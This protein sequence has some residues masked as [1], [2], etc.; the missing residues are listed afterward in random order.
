MT[1]EQIR[2]VVV[3]TGERLDLVTADLGDPALVRDLGARFVLDRAHRSE[4]ADAVTVEG[5]GVGGPFDG[6]AVTARF[7]ADGTDIT[8]TGERGWTFVKAFPMLARGMFE[9]LSFQDPVLR[10][11]PSGNLTF[12][13]KLV[14]TTVL[15]PLDLLFAGVEHDVTGTITMIA[16]IP[17]LGFEV[18]PVPM[19]V[20]FGPAGHSLDLGLFTLDGLRYEIL[21]EPEMDP[22][23]ADL[24]VRGSVTVTGA[25]PFTAYGKR[26]DVLISARIGA[27]R[28][29]ILLL[30]DFREAGRAAFADIAAF[31][32]LPGL[33]IPGDDFQITAPV[34][35]SEVLIA[36]NPG[37]PTLIP[38]L[39]VTLETTQEWDAGVLRLQAVDVVFRVDGPLTASPQVDVMVTGLVAIGARGTLE[40]TAE[41]GD[42]VSF[43]GALREGDP[44]PTLR[45]IY[46]DFTGS[47]AAGHL[48]DLAVHKF[49]VTIDKP[50][51]GPV[52]AAGLLELTGSWAVADGVD[53]QAVLFSLN[54]DGPD[55]KFLTS[56]ELAVFAIRLG[57]MASYTTGQGWFF[58]GRSFPDQEV[59]VGE[60]VD[61]LATRFGAMPPPAPISGLV[62]HD[63][64][65][66][67]ATVDTRFTFGAGVRFPIDTTTVDLTV[68]IDTGARTYGGRIRTVLGDGTDLRFDVHFSDA[69][70]ATRYAAS[71]THGDSD[72]MPPVKSL[73]GALSPTAAGFVPDGLVVSVRDAVLA[74]TGSAYVF[75]VDLVATIDLSRLPV[76]GP[77]L[78]GDGIVGFDPLRVIAATGEVPGT[79]VTKLNALLPAEAASL[80]VQTLPS[81]FT[82]SGLLKLGPL[83]Q[84][85]TLPVTAPAAAPTPVEAKTGDNVLWRQVQTSYGPV[86]VAR[87]GLSYLH[88]PGEPAR[89]AV[90]IDASVTVGGLT[91]SCDGLSAGVSL[92]DPAALPAFDLAGLGLSYAEG[93]VQ[94]SGAF[95]KGTITY[96]DRPYT[97]YSGKA[98]IRTETFTLGALGSYVQLD[99]GPSLFVYA[100]LD[101]P[102]GG[103][104][105]FFVRGIAAGFGY[106]RRLKAPPV[107]KIA[108]FPLVAEALGAQPPGT[109]AGELRK[110]E[111]DLPPSPGDYFLALGVHFTSFEMIDS[112]LLLSIGF[113]HRFELDV[114]GLSTLV[115]PARDAKAAGVTPVAEIQL[116]LKATFAPDDGYFSLLAQL[117]N[118]SYL[119][120]RACR[121]T[122]GFAFVT[123][124]GD[125]H[126]GDFV[127][128]AGGYHPHFPVP[129]HYPSVP[130]LGFNWQVS[131]KLVLKGSAYF[132]L[133]PS[134]LMAGG[135]LAAT[136]EDGSLRAWFDTSLDFLIS[137]QPYHYEAAFH[138]AV[139]ASYTFSFFGTHTITVHV[140]T[141]VRFWGPEFGGDA[142]IDLSVISF[143]IYFGS[144]SGASAKPI[145]WSRFRDTQLP[146]ATQIVTIA[147]RSGAVEPGSG[148]DLG[149]VNPLE[150][151]LLTDA[152]IPSL[153]GT[154]GGAALAGT[155]VAFGVA[156]VGQTGGFTSQHRITITRDGRPAETYFRFEP[157]GKNVPAAQWG[158]ELTPSLTKPVL[159]ENVLTGYV[160][161]P[162]PAADA[163]EPT[164]LPRAAL[165]S[166]TP[167]SVE[168]GAFTW[169]PLPGFVPAADQTLDLASGAAARAAVAG[170]LLADADLATELDLAGLTAADFL[171][172]PKVAAHA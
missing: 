20:L 56:A 170:K 156:P 79:E 141:D 11:P 118:N 153:D 64:D 26:N 32:R 120:D 102:I 135:G 57:V 18:T 59:P 89:I 127:L 75:G 1:I 164:S 19:I 100:F 92:A 129:A 38:Y 132:A 48:P 134:A 9:T 17:A 47:D 36:L 83:E 98:V 106:N 67:F 169:D 78:T 21:G 124:F 143:T 6:M 80:P 113:G 28:D 85:V 35:L 159:V 126:H 142:Y 144:A 130:R 138:L 103:P 140:G 151:E 121:L 70:D 46:G 152:A 104:P 81:G 111:D 139:G 7:A 66:S 29:P 45:E 88:E 162:V 76:V 22:I 61:S 52:T 37:G 163:P 58:S 50:S 73:I 145:E 41:F 91:L 60:L 150:L 5:V 157:V 4:T 95:L 72:P 165:Q 172:A 87:V 149:V 109:L 99:E 77:R 43:S 53:L 148:T 147:L 107:D 168:R 84:P 97:A 40:V 54:V 93:P 2:G 117:T 16:E 108:E 119:L 154:A 63:L 105:I 13:G 116:A 110:L 90:L 82:V 14:I 133:T 123:W 68:A 27:W 3:L 86:H 55:V 74:S 146:P 166:L 171:A 24:T 25:V 62:V 12:T 101:Y 31:L 128:T 125:D 33:A 137:W 136:Y 161:R 8:G 44:F 10:R 49:Q 94:I 155:G 34:V 23:R 51:T 167:V 115:L 39:S 65:V 160:V 15:A 71:Y 42:G 114:L 96:K 30:G 122:G 112:F 69:A 158:D 131:D